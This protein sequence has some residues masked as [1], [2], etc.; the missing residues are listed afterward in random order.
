[1]SII[2]ENKVYKF[3]SF[4]TNRLGATAHLH[5]HIEIVYLLD[6]S[7]TAWIDDRKYEMKAGDLFISFPN[8]VHRY[9]TS[10]YEKAWVLIISDDLCSEFNYWF[11]NFIPKSNLL[12]SG[13]VDNEM[14]EQL[15][16]QINQFNGKKTSE[17]ET[18]NL[19][20]ILLCLLSTIFMGLEFTEER[21]SEVSTI[22]Q[23]LDYCSAH[24]T[25]ELTLEMLEKELHINKYYISHLFSKKLKIKFNDY[26]NNLR[27]D[28][29]TKLLRETDMNMTEIATGS[30]FSTSRTF[31]RSFLKLM[32]ETP[33]EY[34]KKL[35]SV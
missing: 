33:S 20:G 14:I 17:I 11:K 10:Q 5:S 27:V 2:Y 7:S 31:N 15:I 4:L 8:Q 13:S 18:I 30:G 3:T 1:M 35:N 32:G 29:A 12:C 9:T 19:K 16:L 21:I 34:R 25:D 24:F 6:G 26:I 28:R 23:M 22:K